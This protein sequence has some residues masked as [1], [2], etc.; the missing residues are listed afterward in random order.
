MQS[1]K[2]VNITIDSAVHAEMRRFLDLTGSDFSAL[3]EQMCVRFLGEMRPIIK[4]M[5][6]VQNGDAAFNP[7]EF[8]VM[9]LQM[10]GSV[11]VEAGAELK[12]ILQ[13][14][15]T[16]EAEQRAMPKLLEPEAKPI[17]TPKVTKGAKSK[18]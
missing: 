18:K 9:F 12:N 3:V 6:S 2:R 4:R 16:I 13:E 15:D 17:H 1:K 11:Q 10:M 14:L 7:S 5:E 8:R